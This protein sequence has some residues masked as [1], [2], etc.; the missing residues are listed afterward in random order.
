ML[1]FKGTRHL[2][3]LL[4]VAIGRMHSSREWRS[5]PIF[6]HALDL[7][8]KPYVAKLADKQN[9]FILGAR[10]ALDGLKEH[11]PRESSLRRV[12]HQ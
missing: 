11:V 2:A 10:S 7:L 1:V 3:E 4:G 9:A 8:S 12:N 6:K 5:P